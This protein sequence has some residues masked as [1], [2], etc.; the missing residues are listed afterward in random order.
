MAHNT[1]VTAD[2]NAPPITKI[3]AEFVATHPSGKF[4]AHVEREAHRTFMNW[5]GCAIGAH[6]ETPSAAASGSRNEVWNHPFTDRY[7]N[8]M[9]TFDGGVATEFWEMAAGQRPMPA[10]WSSD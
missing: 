6:R 2:A 5:L 4:P 1:K 8:K 10:A 3:L 7:T 9:L